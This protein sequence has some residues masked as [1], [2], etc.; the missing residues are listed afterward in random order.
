MGKRN[1]VSKIID[2]LIAYITVGML[3]LAITI[4]TT[5]WGFILLSPKYA[6]T[7]IFFYPILIAR[8]I[9]NT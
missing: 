2:F 6:L 8:K 5:P 1:R 7:Q 3:Q 9:L 4:C